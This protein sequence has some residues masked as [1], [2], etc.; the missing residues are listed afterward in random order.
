MTFSG[1]CMLK[2]IKKRRF[3]F[4][5]VFQTFVSHVRHLCELT[6]SIGFP[7]PRLELTG[8]FLLENKGYLI[9]QLALSVHHK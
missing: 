8:L 4:S 7:R 3:K 1:Y 5:C 6:Q 9:P 2:N